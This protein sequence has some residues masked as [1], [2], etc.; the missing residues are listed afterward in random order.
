MQIASIP[1][2]DTAVLRACARMGGGM[3]VG[4]VAASGR[5]SL[6]T[7]SVGRSAGGVRTCWCRSSDTRRRCRT[8]SR[9]SSG[10]PTCSLVSI[11]CL[12]AVVVTRGRSRASNWRWSGWG[13]C[14]HTPTSGLVSITGFAAI[15]VACGSWGCCR[16]CS[17]WH[18]TQQQAGDEYG[19]N[20]L[21]FHTLN[22]HQLPTR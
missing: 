15:I 19:P 14:G 20:Q 7:S 10:S 18:G 2:C 21:N 4:I 6:R 12:R 11:T 22:S 17:S 1:L 13:S 8:R 3:A 5:C 9:C 16:G